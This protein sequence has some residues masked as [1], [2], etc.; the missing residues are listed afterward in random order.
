MIE[1][2]GQVLGLHLV[3]DLGKADKIGKTNRELL[4]FADD[5]DIL[6]PRKNRLINLRSKIWE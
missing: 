1:Q 4:A 2:L 3:G 6:L 5:L